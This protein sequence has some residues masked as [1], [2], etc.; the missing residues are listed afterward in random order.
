MIASSRQVE[1]TSPRLALKLYPLNADALLAWG[2]DA[3]GDA[4][5]RVP[6]ETIAS[7]AEAAIPF[8]AGDARIYSLT[9]EIM[10][11]RG[12]EAATHAMFDHALLLGKTE[13]HALQWSIQRAVNEQDYREVT[14]RLDVLFRRWPERIELLAEALPVIYSN[15]DGYRLLLAKVSGNPPWRSRL[16]A[17][18]TADSATNLGFG[19]R[20]LQDLAVGNSPPT[21]AETARVLSSLFRRED[22]NAAYRTFLLTLSPAEKD[23]SGFVF[24]GTFRQGPSA[25]LFDWNLRPQPGVTVSLPKDAGTGRNPSGSGLSL[26]FNET[27]VLGVGVNQYLLLPPGDYGIGFQASAFAAKLPKKLIWSIRCRNSGTQLLNMDVPEGNYQDRAVEAV[28]SVPENCP[29]QVLGLRTNAIAESWSERYSG[30]LLI[31]N[32]RISAV[33]S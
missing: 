1:K 25:R 10:R 27:P 7:A 5:N 2:I 4:D 12:Q 14:D 30:R 33:Q 3:L 15:E 29:F 31:H 9:G 16:I 13:I 21:A 11:R 20:L 17:N 28:F 24:N 32:I 8:N 19:V 18:L 23:L 26:E 22:Y 6:L